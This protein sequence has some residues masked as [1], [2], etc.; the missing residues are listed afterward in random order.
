MAVRFQLP[1]ADV[2]DGISPSDG[3]LLYFY[4]PG[5][6]TLKT[7]FSDDALT[8]P[9]TNPVVSDSDGV[10]ANIWMSGRDRYKVVLK[11][12]NAVQIWDADPVITGL[13]SSD[14]AII[15]DNVSD[16]V[17]SDRLSIG[18]TV[19]TAGYTTAGD[20]GGNRYKIVA[21][22]TGTDDGGGFIDLVAHQAQGVFNGL[23]VN[24]KQ[25]GAFGDSSNDDAPTIQAAIDYLTLGGCVFLPKGG[26]R[27]TV[28]LTVEEDNIT[29]FGVGRASKI[30]PASTTA[31][32]FDVSNAAN[33]V[34]GFSLMHL[35]I[36][37]TVT[38]ITAGAAIHMDGVRNFNIT[39]VIIDDAF[40]GFQLSG[41]TQGVVND[42]LCLYESDN[43]GT[44]AGRRYVLIEETANVNVG[45][46]HCGDVFFSNFN[47]RCGN[48]N[49]CETGVEIFSGDGIWFNNFHIGNCTTYNLD[50]N[51]NSS[52]KCTGL[53]FSDGWFDLGDATAVSI[54]GSTP[55][56]IGG[57]AFRNNKLLGGNTGTHGFDISGSATEIVID[58]NVISNY[59]FSGV[60]IRS[61]F[62]GSGEITNNIIRDC[63]Q[64]SVGGS[65]AVDFQSNTVWKIEGNT[66]RGPRH[67][68]HVFISG[69]KTEAHIDRNILGGSA[70]VESMTELV[71]TNITQMDNYNFNPTGSKSEAV[72]ASPY[73][74]TNTHGY[75]VQML[76]YGGTVSQ[77]K[78]N[79]TTL[80]GSRSEASLVVPVGSTVEITYSSTPF[81][82]IQG[83]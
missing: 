67:A 81:A 57:Y 64:D 5:T 15:F 77:I 32:T 41:G 17:S 63:S 48:L 37:P 3:A 22:A 10:F 13:S 71:G 75:P 16:M 34:Y 43:G 36:E 11:D 23:V 14:A 44:I 46:K 58:D 20:G 29:I 18:D 55:T 40:I 60:L 52:I 28:P 47:G 4:V 53:L 66:I 26:Y 73:T 76:I 56:T 69:T 79:G 49:Y 8:T 65:N 35:N 80:G 9:N 19:D 12:K 83:L 50:I 31:D 21:A 45:S 68:R 54:R 24:V 74:Y 25:F 38:P 72:G 61:T 42:L 39:D 6:T 30:K 33:A 7:T 82:Y 51:A 70:T 1:F 27:T 62:T 2:G 59:D 78:W